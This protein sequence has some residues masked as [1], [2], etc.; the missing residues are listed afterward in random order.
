LTSF[1]ERGKIY[2][3]RIPGQPGDTK[4]RPVWVVSGNARNQF[5]HDIIVVPLSTTLHLSPTHVRLPSGSG[6]LPHDSMAKCELVTTLD[7]I[8]LTRGPIG[9]QITQSQMQEIEKP[10]MRAIGIAVP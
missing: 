8:F 2:W 10:I 6:G 7:K 3:A 4:D 9:G 5:A 1:P